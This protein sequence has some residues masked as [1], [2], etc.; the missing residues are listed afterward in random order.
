[1]IGHELGPR[2]IGVESA[3]HPV[4]VGPGIGTLLVLVVAV[5][6][7]VVDDIEPVSGP[8]LAVAG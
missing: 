1:L 7:A 3:D 5:R 4:T 2:E 6:V 8:A